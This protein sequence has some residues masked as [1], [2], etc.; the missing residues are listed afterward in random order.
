MC[1]AQFREVLLWKQDRHLHNRARVLRCSIPDIYLVYTGECYGGGAYQ[2][3]RRG[4]LQTWALESRL[5][6]LYFVK[7][8]Q[9]L[10]L[11]SVN[12]IDI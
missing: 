12:F 6:L 4:N 1:R 11:L 9:W 5:G 8:G 2:S 3:N 7:L 10:K